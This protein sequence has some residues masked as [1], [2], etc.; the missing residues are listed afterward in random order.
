MPSLMENQY[1]RNKNTFS[2]GG[3]AAAAAARAAQVTGSNERISGLD[4][5]TD[6]NIDYFR[7]ASDMSTLGL[8]GDIWNMKAPTWKSPGD[9]DKIETNYDKDD[10]D[11]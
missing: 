1:Q 8:Y 9:L 6:A 11:K 3:A 5:V 4:K 7:K 2:A 10:D